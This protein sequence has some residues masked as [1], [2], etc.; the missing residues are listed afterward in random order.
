MRR[1]INIFFVLSLI[2]IFQS[3]QKD[4]TVP[5]STYACSL[6]FPDESAAHPK[7][8]IYQQIIDKYIAKGVLGTSVYLRD[9]DGTFLGT[10]GMADIASGIEIQSCNQFII[11]SITKPIT[12]TL[13]FSLIEDGLLSLEDKMT[14]HLEKSITDRLPNGDEIQIKHLLKHTAGLPDHY[15]FPYYFDNLNQERNILRQEDY[16]KYTYD[17]DPVGPVGGQFAYSNVGYVLMGM[18]LEAASG[19]T[20]PQL[21]DEKI[22]NPLN[23]TSGHYGAGENSI[24]PGLVKGYLDLNG[25]GQMVES[26]FFY[27]EELNTADG[28][29]CMNPQDLGR[30]FE[31]WVKGNVINPTSVEEMQNWYIY[32][33]N[34]PGDDDVAYGY[35][36]G[37]YD[38]KYG[39]AVGHDG[40]VGG[41]STI[42]QIFPDENR[43][44]VIF[45]N[46]TPVKNNDAYSDF[47]K[48]LAEELFK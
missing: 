16:L 21:Y 19:K 33:D 41:F 14:Q 35:G 27:E 29:I 44:L 24:P 10:G 30:F 3:C 42:A 38:T 22:F 26:E 36:I 13:T 40:G 15:D 31:E 45:F 32:P 48:E 5:A 20:M 25:N 17:K 47:V 1:F 34:E 18:I 12:A 6:S 9:N 23:L 11:G 37:K 8:E 28:G 7:A 43:T 2:S 39:N 46:S 4:P